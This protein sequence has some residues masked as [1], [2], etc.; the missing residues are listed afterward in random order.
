MNWF[1]HGRSDLVVGFGKDGGVCEGG[2]CE[3]LKKGDKAFGQCG[4]N[5]SFGS[6]AYL[7]CEPC[8]EKFLVERKEEPTDCHDCKGEFPRSQTKHYKAYDT[9]S[10]EAEKFRAD[11]CLGCWEAPRHQARLARDKEESSRDFQDMFGGDDDDDYLYYEG[12][13]DDDV[14]DPED[15]MIDL[16]EPEWTMGDS[17][18][19]LVPPHL[20]LTVFDRGNVPKGWPN[21]YSSTIQKIVVST[22]LKPEDGMVLSDVLRR[23]LENPAKFTGRDFITIAAPYPTKG[24]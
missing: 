23:K 9:E 7:M 16:R 3:H 1:T 2:N 21:L 6:E 19:V 12:P 11:I 20:P 13:D 15:C 4:E 14:E 18:H 22:R 17:I 10:I 5:D 24:K 8:Y